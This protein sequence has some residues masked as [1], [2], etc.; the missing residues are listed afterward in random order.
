[1]AYTT[2]LNPPQISSKIPAFS[3]N[4][5]KIPFVLNKAV[6]P[7][8]F[9]K[10]AIIVK[11][12][13]T[14]TTVMTGETSSYYYDY[15]KHCY[16][17]FF[18]NLKDDYK[19]SPKVGQYYKI[20]IACVT[21]NVAGF[22]ST[23]GIIKYTSHPS[24]S[25]LDRG[26]TVNNTYEYTGLYSQAQGD[27]TEKVYSYCF[28]LYNKD[29]VL[30]ATSGE[31][32]HNSSTDTD[33]FQ[34]VDTWTIRKA[35]EPNVSY[36]IEYVITT[37]NGLVVSSPRYEIIE[38]QFEDPSVHADL[39]AISN[40][41]DGYIEVSLAGKKDNSYVNG[42]CVLLRS[43]SE[44]NFDS[45]NELTRFQLCRWDTNTILTLCKDHTVAQGF[46]YRYAIQAYNSV[47][48]YSNRL[49]NIEGDI[50]CD[51]EDAF[52]WDGERQLKIKFN[53]KITGF[54]SSILETKTNTI[55]SKYPF[56]FRNG[57]V[58]YKEFSISGL[59]SILGDE[60][61][62]FLT[63]LQDKNEKRYDTPAAAG[64]MADQGQC[65][66]ADNY[67]KERQF[68]MD[69]LAWL[70]NGKP[71]L[72]RSAAEGNYIVRLMN[73]TLTP[74]DTLGRM[75][76]TFNCQAC[77]VA[78]CNFENLQSL[79]FTVPSYVETRSLQFGQIDFGDP[80]KPIPNSVKMLS[81]KVIEFPSA[82]M[83][84]ITNA[85]G[86]HVEATFADGSK[87]ELAEISGTYIF[88]NDVLKSNP[89]I[90]LTLLG[91]SWGKAQITYTYYDTAL[92]AFSFI[93]KITTTDRITQTL[94]ETGINLISKMEDIRI[95]TG[96]FH[97]IRVQPRTQIKIY[98]N[99]GYYYTNHSEKIT[100]L[101]PL[102]IYLIVNTQNNTIEKYFDGRYGMTPR[103][104]KQLSYDFKLIGSSLVDFSLSNNPTTS[105]RY[106]ALTN[107]NSVDELYAGD[108]IIL[109]MV[110]QENEFLYAVELATSDE[111]DMNTFIAKSA[112]LT[113]KEEY[114]KALDEGN[115]SEAFIA[116]LKNRVDETY[117]IYITYLAAA[118]E[119]VKEDHNV[120]F[121][122]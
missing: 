58:E 95:K 117:K 121:A 34:S 21:D 67:R 113:A 77:E 26:D 72:F 56:I 39:C 71:K 8:Q 120:D 93:H 73:A 101:N 41:E 91:D 90:Y 106:E 105:A 104:I 42:Y 102:Y 86:L 45:W 22:Y 109:D 2:R 54:K 3:E 116:Q 46:S 43:S 13:S 122:I 24:V 16:F 40:P 78:D 111:I 75:L 27:A 55:G 119:R 98:Y 1:M 70:T 59:L 85:L 83:M 74:N 23:T 9:N 108:G 15:D 18:N 7:I 17:A 76:H 68:K 38:V 36:T 89:I 107:I 92:D 49:L 81:D 51:F 48:T 50:V 60:N 112:W 28:N 65:L 32:I 103:D 64:Y 53:P 25:I 57:N 115:G 37:M 84:S 97:Y 6:S 11:T 30:V 14:N 20:S 44:D 12:V 118:I 80:N 52:L 29:N 87:T 69:V 62:E 100:E 5:M 114:E 10:I 63:G 79:G 47:G 82:C 4:V 61:D 110:Y 31:Q 94:G 35:L 88:N 96:A 19:F 99:N 66:S 33:L